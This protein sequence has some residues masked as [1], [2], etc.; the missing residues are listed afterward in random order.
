VTVTLTSIKGQLYEV[1]CGY[2]LE[3]KE[4]ILV[5]KGITTWR[6]SST[7]MVPLIVLTSNGYKLKVRCPFLP[8][9]DALLMDLFDG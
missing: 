9:A 2:C 7:L 1:Y 6:N 5:N 3:T 4:G 8:S